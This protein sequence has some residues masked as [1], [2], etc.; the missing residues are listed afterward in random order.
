MSFRRMIGAILIILGLITVTLP[1]TREFILISLFLVVYGGVTIARDLQGSVGGRLRGLL[2]SYR[3]SA[4]ASS[5]QQ[6]ARIDPLLP[7]RVLKLAEAREGSLTV[8]VVA[9]ALN[10]GL[11]ECQ[12]ALDELVRKGAAM[13]D[14]DLATGVATYRF[15]EFLPH[16]I[17][18]ASPL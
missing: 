2:G 10:V 3:R 17:E 7:V 14:V 13:V 5:R 12:V 9:M 1:F 4:D 16:T 6:A 11:D 15:P 8:S 18:G